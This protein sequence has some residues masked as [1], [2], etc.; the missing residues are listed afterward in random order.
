MLFS[1]L[2]CLHTSQC[3]SFFFSLP[4]KHNPDDQEYCKD[5]RQPDK[6]ADAEEGGADMAQPAFCVSL[7][8]LIGNRISGEK[9]GVDC[10]GIRIIV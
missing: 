7:C 9:V 8:L 6:A 4:P 2:L 3:I 5:R 10:Y 1:L